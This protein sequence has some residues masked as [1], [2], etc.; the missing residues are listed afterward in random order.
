MHLTLDELLSYTDEERAKW[1]EWFADH[2]N[3]P[4]KLAV[5]MDVHPTI[6]AL[7]LHCFW[8]ELFYAHWMKR[9][10]LTPERMKEIS[11]SFAAD[12]ADQVFAFGHSAR[13]ALR[14]A[15]S[16]FNEEDWEKTHEV[17]GRGLH[18]EGSAR[19]LIAHIL[20][21]EIRHWAQVAVTVRQ[22]GLAPPGEHDLLFSNSFGPL[23]KKV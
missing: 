10:I 15:T 13:K 1:E 14:E 11:E 9:D 3:E 4:F 21:H 23:V 18:I 7:I 5:P 17:E 19:K 8:A 22:H 6:G 16:A 2:G 12:Q 20:V